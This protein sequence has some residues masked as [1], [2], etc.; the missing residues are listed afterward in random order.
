M[1]SF[2][3]LQLM[4]NN[5]NYLWRHYQLRHNHLLLSENLQRCF[6]A[7]TF[8]LTPPIQLRMSI[9]GQLI[10]NKSYPVV[11]QMVQMNLGKLASAVYIAK[12]EVENP[13][14]ITIIKE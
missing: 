13:V 6:L 2:Y 7:K 3:L 12:V 5:Q 4:L 11:N 10:S 1:Y 14:S 8:L 9:G